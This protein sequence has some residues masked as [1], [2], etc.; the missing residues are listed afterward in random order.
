MTCVCIMVPMTTDPPG[1]A[2]PEVAG[3]GGPDTRAE[4]TQLLRASGHGDEEAFAKLYDVTAPRVFGLVLRDRA[5]AEEVTQEAFLEI[6]RTSP[7]FDPA[8]G[9]ALGWLMTI[10][11]RRAV[12]RVRSAQA[13]TR[14]DT[15]YEES[16]RAPAYDVTAEQ[17]HQNLEAGV[18][19]EALREL[20]RVQREALELAYFGGLTHREVAD[21]L[22]LPLGTAKTRIRDGLTRLRDTLGADR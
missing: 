3:H 19:R 11:H 22:D 16:R 5:Q 6:W 9:S 7:R 13:Q 14:R 4:L 12:D 18:V 1:R 20:T 10:A 21:R 8:R 15:A 17:A 2:L